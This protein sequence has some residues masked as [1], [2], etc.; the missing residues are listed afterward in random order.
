MNF[1]HSRKL[2]VFLMTAVL[3]A[4]MVTCSF[5]VKV[6]AT[7]NANVRAKAS[8]SSKVLTV[9]K[10]GAS[11]TVL[12]T[13][14]SYY[15]VKVNG[16][17]GYV[18]GSCVATEDELNANAA[19]P[20]ET[21]SEFGKKVV[22]EV[23]K[24]VGKPYV[25]GA[26]GPDSFDCSGLTYYVYK[27]CG[28]T[29][30]RVAEDQYYSAKKVSR[31]NLQPGDLVFFTSEPGGS[32]ISHV[33]IYIGNDKMIHAANSNVGVVES[34]LASGYYYTHYYGAGRY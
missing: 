23:K 7:K 2:K 29:I 27:K 21:A 25:Y 3:M 30:P 28:K 6:T 4:L 34:D 15:K 16:E 12:G 11:R 17:V 33:G 26:T 5:A 24:H 31:A 19:S 13:S 8:A 22:K 1:L 14:G 10:K 9:M 18:K 32:Y 20:E